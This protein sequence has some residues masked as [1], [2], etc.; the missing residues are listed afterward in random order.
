MAACRLPLLLVLPR[1]LS[2]R[3][4]DN[5]FHHGIMGVTLQLLQLAWLWLCDAESSMLG[6]GTGCIAVTP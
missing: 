4:G 1:L 6:P 2:E 5:A 3:D